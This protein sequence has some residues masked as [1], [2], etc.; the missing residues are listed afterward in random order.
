M[1]NVRKAIEWVVTI[2]LATLMVLLLAPYFLIKRLVKGDIYD[3]FQDYGDDYK[4][5]KIRL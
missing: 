3:H 2:P 4:G 5:R 1:R